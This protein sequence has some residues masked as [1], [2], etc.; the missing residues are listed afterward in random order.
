[1]NTDRRFQLVFDGYVGQTG[2]LGGPAVMSSAERD[3]HN[4][5]VHLAHERECVHR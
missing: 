5:F 1:M 2:L 4:S 3:V